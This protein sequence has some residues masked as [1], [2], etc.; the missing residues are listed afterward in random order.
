MKGTGVVRPDGHGLRPG[1]AFAV[2]MTLILAGPGPLPRVVNADT[3]AA[4]GVEVND[5]D[6]VAAIEDLI[7]RIRSE[8]Q[9]LQQVIEQRGEVEAELSDL[10]ERLGELEAEAERQAMRVEELEAERSHD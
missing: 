8:R 3:G 1:A 9:E 7:E 5:E 6:G 2:V 10:R 4:A